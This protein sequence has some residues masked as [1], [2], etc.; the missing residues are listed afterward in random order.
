MGMDV[1]CEPTLCDGGSD[2]P[3]APMIDPGEMR[4]LPSLPNPFSQSA[5]LRFV[6][7][8]NAAVTLD[9][10][11]VFGRRVRRLLDGFAPAGAGQVLWN[12]RDDAGRCLPAGLYFT[13]LA[14]NR[15]ALGRPIVLVR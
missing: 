14:G 2:V 9:I 4:I 15:T 3:E 12:G 11:D 13:R 5:Q 6:L 10:C 8:S 7:P 1:A